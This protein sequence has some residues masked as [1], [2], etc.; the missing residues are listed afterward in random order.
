ME[1]HGRV[2]P[3]ESPE[4]HCAVRTAVVVLTTQFYL[5]SLSVVE[6]NIITSNVAMY[7]QAPSSERDISVQTAVVVLI[8]LFYVQSFSLSELNTLAWIDVE[9]TAM[10]GAAQ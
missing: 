10:A 5:Q 2:L 6:L 7:A 9:E 4:Q 8:A 1:C 3:A